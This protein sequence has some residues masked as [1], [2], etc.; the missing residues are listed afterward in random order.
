MDLVDW[1]IKLLN[2]IS[3]MA[4]QANMGKKGEASNLG[5][6]FE[7]ENKSLHLI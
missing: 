4:K 7:S 1:F 3:N 6:D 5:A 2:T